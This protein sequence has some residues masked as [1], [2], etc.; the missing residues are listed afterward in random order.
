M[1]ENFKEE[2]LKEESADTKVSEGEQWTWSPVK[3]LGWVAVVIVAVLIG[4][5]YLHIVLVQFPFNRTLWL[6]PMRCID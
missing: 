6:C 4:L 1:S 5:F 2:K 3:I